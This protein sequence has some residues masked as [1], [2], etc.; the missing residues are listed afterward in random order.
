MV[1][2]NWFG[3]VRTRP[4]PFRKVGTYLNCKPDF[5]FGSGWGLNF[6]PDF[7]YVRRSSGS[8]LG[9]EPDCGSTK[10]GSDH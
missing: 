10:E 9:S 3:C 4:N 2:Y 6:G 1:K 8:N 7:G 5:A